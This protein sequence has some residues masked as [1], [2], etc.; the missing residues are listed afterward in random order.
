MSTGMVYVVARDGRR[1]ERDNYKLQRDAQERASQLYNMLKYWND[2]D[3]H[4]V[5][6]IRTDKPNQIR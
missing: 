1:I 3:M 6:I 2:P 4:K 5:E